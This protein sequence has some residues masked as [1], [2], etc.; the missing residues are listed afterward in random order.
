MSINNNINT[1]R[2]LVN[3]NNLRNTLYTRN[4]YVPNKEYPFINQSNTDRVVGAISSVISIITP[5]KGFDLKDSIIGRLVTNKTPLTEIGLVMLGKQFAMNSMSHLA[6]QTFPTIKLANLFDGNKDTKLFTAN[7]NLAI[8]KKQ[9]SKF[10]D[11]LNDLVYYYPMKNYPFDKKS[12]NSDFIKNTGTGQLAFLYREINQNIY[13]QNDTTLIST[14]NVIGKPIQQRSN[15]L[16][17][18]IFFDFSNSLTNPYLNYHPNIIA[19]AIANGNMT[20]AYDKTST[21]GQE[22]APNA[23]FI[24]N[25]FGTTNKS[26]EYN[27][28]VKGSGNDWINSENEFINDNIQNKLVWGRD[29]VED[30]ANEKLIQLHGNTD[31]EINN[32]NQSES[33]NNFNIK[34]GLLEYT[35]NLLNATEGNVGDITRKAF[36]NGYKLVGFNGSALWRANTS[37]YAGNAGI[38]DKEGVRQHTIL[39]QYDRFAK[40]IR[41]NGNKIYGGNPDSVIYNT[42]MPRIHPTINTETAKIDSKNLMFSIENLAVG[43]ISK[44]DY[45]IIDDEYGSPI[46]ASEVGPFNGR[47]MW[48][49]PYNMDV[50]ETAS[51][52]YE[53]TVMVGRGEPIYNYQNSERSAIVTFTLLVDYPQHLKNYKGVNKQREIAE[54]FAFG[55][56]PYVDKF[57]SIEGYQKKEATLT[58]EI[59]KIQGKAKTAEPEKLSPREIRMV[60]PNDEPNINADIS[61]Y[62]DRLYKGC[63]YEITEGCESSDGTGF[64]LNKDIFVISGLTDSTKWEKGSGYYE[65]VSSLLT[66]FSQYNAIGN[67]QAGFGDECLLNKQLKEIYKDEVNRNLYDIIIVGGSSKFYLGKTGEA[68]YNDALG[69]RRAEVAK[70]FIDKRLQALFGKDSTQLGINIHSIISTGSKTADPLNATVAAIPDKNTKSERHAT[71]TI[72][73]NSNSPKPTAAQISQDEQDSIAEKQKQIEAVR[74][75]V[76][77][78]KDLNSDIF[79]E[80]KGVGANANNGTDTGIL[81]GFKSVSDDYYYPVF[82]SQTPEDFHKRLTFLHQCTRQGA[83]MRTAATTDNSGTLR[84]RN[85]VFGRQPICILRVGDFFY[86]KVIIE[87]VNFDYTDTTWDM[88]PEGFGMQPMIAKIT[89]N[90]KVIGGQSLKGP[91]DALQNAVSFNFYGN[92]TYSNTG[93]YKLPSDQAK[94]QESYMKGVLTLKQNALA[95]KYLEDWTNEESH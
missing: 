5:F 63:V 73:R 59:S 70:I 78:L 3:S 43:V 20:S 11:F 28:G 35:R 14:G 74:T 27:A 54:F 55:G 76:R 90:M 75:E 37:K 9:Q 87:S 46:P 84:A 68:A 2:L 89:L 80:R 72:V 64:G 10:Q 24:N 62:V 51:A 38:A 44:G 40:A 33:L 36:R 52:K 50:Q 77:R 60:F 34:S 4:L 25:N 8:T 67:N 79:N 30:D 95:D 47:I 61:T 42:V 31:S 32:F 49:P 12:K 15:L 91:I 26:P 86:T 1:S 23:D 17:N 53:S 85:S 18:K 93:T 48:F 7:I 81:H 19:G 6:Q 16:A 29:G 71:I 13:K 57:V 56:D 41:F 66:N 82:H 94:N 58:N 45:G 39:D 92:S 88:N 65:L 21:N 22:Y 69:L 83:A